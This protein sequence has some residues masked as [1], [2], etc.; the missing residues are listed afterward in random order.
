MAVL[1]SKGRL[2]E[3]S[4]KTERERCPRADLQSVSGRLWASVTPVLRPVR[5]VQSLDWDR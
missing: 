2:P 1:L 5:E 3:A 4:L